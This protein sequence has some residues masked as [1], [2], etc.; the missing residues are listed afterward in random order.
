MIAARFAAWAVA[1]AAGVACAQTE[2]T[3]AWSDIAALSALGAGMMGQ[4][5]CA[6]AARAFEEVVRLSPGMAQA[7]VNL[8]IALLNRQEEGDEE[9][10]LELVDEVVRTD[11]D[12]ARARYVRGLIR[13]HRGEPGAARRDFE[14]AAQGED[15]YA[16]YLAGQCCAM[17]RR[18][19]E[20]L[21]WYERA[22]AADD[23]LISAPFAAAGTLRSLGRA[24]EAEA[25]LERFESR[26]AS[27]AARTF[28]FRYTRMGPL[29]QAL[30][31]APEPAPA[32][33]APPEGPIFD[34]PRA[35][36][37]GGGE[38]LRW[39]ER[40]AAASIT[41]SDITG[42]GLI[43]L[44]IAGALDGPAPNAVLTAQAGGG[45][46]CD[47]AHP[48]A[49]VPGVRAALW[50][51]IDDDGLTDAVL[52]RDGPDHVWRQTAPGAWRDASGEAGLGGGDGATVDG[53][54]ADLDHDGDLDILQ[55][56]GDGTVRLLNNNR[57][58][59]FTD[60]AP[61]AG[62]AGDGR[63]A[64]Q[65]LVAD[66]DADRDLDIIIIREDPPHDVWLSERTWTYRRAE[67]WD[68]LISAPLLAAVA[69][70]LRADGRPLVVGL[71]TDGS[72]RAWGSKGIEA[73]LAGAA[74]MEHGHGRL[75]ICDAS[76]D[77]RLGV[78]ASRDAGWSLLGESGGGWGVIESGHVPGLGGWGCIPLEPVRGAS[79]VGLTPAGP[80]AWG[81]GPGRFGFAAVSLSGSAE[82]GHPARS[83][84]SGIGAR[85][86][87]W[88]GGRWTV[89][90]TLRAD[91]GP[92][93]AL[94]PLPLGL[95]GA[96]TIELLEIEWSDGVHQ[97]EIGLA[98]GEVHRIVETQRQLSSCPVLFAWDGGRFAFVSD[99]L[100]VGGM[101]Y[102]IEPGVYAPPRPVEAFPM[103]EGLIAERAGRYA[104]KLSEPMEEACYLDAVRLVEH[105]LPPGWSMT[106]DERMGVAGPEPTGEPVFFR[107]WLAPV[108]A[109]DEEGRDVLAELEAADGRAAPLPPLDRRFIG[110]LAREHVLTLEFD[111]PLGG[112]R[113]V[114][115]AD[116]WV[117]YPYSQTMFAAWQ[118]EAAYSAPTIEARGADGGWT[119][120]A[121][122]FG[123]PAG[124]PRQMS[125]PLNGLPAGATA[126]RVR[127][128]MEV[129]WDRI[130]V[131]LAE[132]C[133]EARRMDLPLA[134]ARLARTGFPRRVGGPGER[135]DFN[136]DD[137]LSAW[138][139][140][141]QLGFYTA[142]G[143][144]ADLLRRADG[145]LVVF[146]PGEEVHME[147]DTAG[148]PAPT[149]GWS[150]RHVLELA[151][152]CKD[153]DLF[154]FQG[155]TVE[156]LPV[157]APHGAD[158][159]RVR[160]QFGR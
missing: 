129:Y 76:G 65:A 124:M 56:R 18:P 139:T 147:F 11:A 111:E 131:A 91:S 146:G 37:V 143:A 103:P 87:A 5:R 54:L 96:D 113:P 121:E 136:Y 67:G 125:A 154:T 77:G 22:I 84:A 92:G 21:A 73:E 134:S 35:L 126:L 108:R 158:E 93:Q 49:S 145:A 99:V 100:G 127:G 40:A 14:H 50:G 123:Y 153:M 19:D 150:R 3:A 102:M 60:I 128:T 115:I 34:A 137:R 2:E 138:D 31:L 116:G 36:R 23:M 20:A 62:I 68:A 27:P 149:P 15:A 133:P 117:E 72:V 101:G 13:L 132:P 152:W 155:E 30:P 109:R 55:V 51:D 160:F 94:T 38:R 10:A 43:D 71:G 64:R 148:A 74:P 6:D 112:P 89:T 135:P 142:F 75:A 29:A 52:V 79:I 85:V 159:R 8:A 157:A 78:V 24:P 9:R 118:A 95:A 140:R 32:Q 58:G 1:V 114:L 81:P 48:L 106:L 151:G 61:R 66:L 104:L 83:N 88:T 86:S 98:G 144:V 97:S 70:D 107:R 53:V 39:R 59:T 25:M 12:D 156:P 122:Q 130:F 110:R 41:A 45:Y 16:A 33:R 69:A 120:I 7:R 28:E 47:L 44:F 63:R 105:H 17:L 90:G 26:R 57:D 141:H 82:P 42:N 4:Y 119:T 46:E 80:V